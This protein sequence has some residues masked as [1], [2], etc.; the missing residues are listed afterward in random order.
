MKHTIK[1][2]IVKGN[3]PLRETFSLIF[4]EYIFEDNRKKSSLSTKQNNYSKK[5]IG[6]QVAF[7]AYNK[8]DFLQLFFKNM[9]GSSF[10]TLKISISLLLHAQLYVHLPLLTKHFL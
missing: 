4:E 5:K 10:S 1:K 9:L 8:S 3:L 2:G 6:G 7:K